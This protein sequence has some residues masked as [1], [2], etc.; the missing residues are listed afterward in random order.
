MLPSYFAIIGA[1]IASIGGLKYLYDTVFGNTK[2][3]RV[4][5]LLWAL[6]PI[7]IFVSQRSQGVSLGLWAT[8]AA[9]FTPALIFLASFIN[10]KAYWKT[11]LLDYIC[12]GLAIVGITLWAVTDQPNVAILFSILADLAAAVPTIIKS[13]KHPESESWQAYTISCV[14]F[15]LTLLAISDF[16]FESAAFVIY[17]TVNEGVLAYLASRKHATNTV[18]SKKQNT[19]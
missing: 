6:F 3:N 11:E 14:G 7:I 17:L 15:L 16:T 9:G 18:K 13:A 1:I 8:V 2:P 12:L 4:T 10:K 19:K 5:W